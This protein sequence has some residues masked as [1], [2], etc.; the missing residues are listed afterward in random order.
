VE[1]LASVARAIEREP[2]TVEEATS[3]L[4]LA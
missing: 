2:A 3:A 4:G 1:R